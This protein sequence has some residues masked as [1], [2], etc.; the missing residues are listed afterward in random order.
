[1]VSGVNNDY[2]EEVENTQSGG[3]EQSFECG[4]FKKSQGTITVTISVSKHPIGGCNV[5]KIPKCSGCVSVKPKPA[6]L[7][8]VLCLSKNEWC[9]IASV[10]NFF[11]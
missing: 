3:G 8:K 1:M 5:V 7:K 6:S 2:D 4:P 11:G 10:D 9:S